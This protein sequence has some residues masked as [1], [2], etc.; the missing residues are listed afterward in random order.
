MRSIQRVN[1]SFSALFGKSDGEEGG[2]E[3][4]SSE[5][6]RT[7]GWIYN[8]TMVAEL[9]RIKLDDAWELPVLQFLNDLSYLK[10]K[11]KIDADQQAKLLRRR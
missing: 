2:S 6:D 10:I 3:S 1:E 11:R 7:Y 9:E 8:A 5:F 4:D